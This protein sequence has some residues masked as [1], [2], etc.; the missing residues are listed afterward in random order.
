MGLCTI[1]G[2]PA[3]LLHH[4]HKECEELQRTTRGKMIE[5]AR[6]AA[7][8][9]TPAPDLKDSLAR[10]ASAAYGPDSWVRDA[11]LGGWEK[12]VDAALGDRLLTDAEQAPLDA[13]AHRFEL[14]PAEMNRNGVM[15][16]LGKA[17]ILRDLTEKGKVPQVGPV[18]GLPFNLLNTE[19]LVW[20]FKDVAYYE[21]KTSTHYEGRSAGVSIRVMKG[22][23]Y[24]TGGFQGNPVQTTAAV[25]S[26]TGF[27]GATTKHV[28]FTGATKSFRIPYTKIVSFKSYS[29]GIGIQRDAANAR[30]QTFVT[31]DG[32]FTYNLLTNLSHLGA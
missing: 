2:Q 20:L 27:F 14:T 30:F 19:S 16:K 7:T 11:L 32:W 3:G 9:E 5:V 15:E 8:G 17:E 25:L 28:Y 6:A 23:Y 10:M 4:V 21:F 1:C 12:A 24:R 13:F 18:D 29:D 31:G 26:D 22:L